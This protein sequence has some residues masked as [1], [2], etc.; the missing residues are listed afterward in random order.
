[1]LRH[2][3]TT[4]EPARRRRRVSGRHQWRTTQRCAGERQC[5]QRSL[6][7]RPQA[8]GTG[9]AVIR[10]TNAG[11]ARNKPPT[12][13]TRKD[14]IGSPNSDPRRSRAQRM[15]CSGRPQ[16]GH[17]AIRAGPFASTNTPSPE[18]SAR[19]VAI[20][21]LP[22]GI[23]AGLVRVR[24]GHATRLIGRDR[25]RAGA[26]LRYGRGFVRVHPAG[27]SASGGASGGSVWVSPRSGTCA[28]APLPR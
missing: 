15:S 27:I 3:P 26:V 8:H 18:W 14:T 2:I 24:K 25:S 21:N 10:N 12:Q 5:R 23:S 4:I 28:T 11:T 20:C 16:T 6:S 19:G 1:M 9:P 17:R 13:Q 7:R 22:N